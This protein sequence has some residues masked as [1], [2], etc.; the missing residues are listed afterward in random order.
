ML[1]QLSQLLT[2]VLQMPVFSVGLFVAAGLLAGYA[3]TAG[4]KGSEPDIQ[5][6][7]KDLHE[8]NVE[9]QETLRGQRDAHARLER[10]HA[11]QHDE[12]TRL[13]V[14]Q[15]RVEATLREH[16]LEHSSLEDS[17]AA[18][19]EIRQRAIRDLEQERQ[20]RIASEES[21]ETLARR[22]QRQRQELEE[23]KELYAAMQQE[24][25]LLQAGTR[26]WDQSQHD[27]RTVRQ[28]HDCLVKGLHAAAKE[29]DGDLTPGTPWN[30]AS[31]ATLL[32]RLAG[33]LQQT[34]LSLEH[35][36]VEHQEALARMHNEKQQRE[37]LSQILQDT[38]AVGRIAVPGGGDFAQLEATLTRT[39]EELEEARTRLN[40]S[41]EERSAMLLALEQGRELFR[42]LQSD[43][44]SHRRALETIERQRDEAQQ[45]L[46]R[47][48]AIP[49]DAELTQ[50][51]RRQLKELQTEH[52]TSQRRGVELQQ[53]LADLQRNLRSEEIEADRLR[54][55]RDELLSDLRAE[56]EE[57]RAQGVALEQQ[58]AK[59]R[60]L[61]EELRELKEAAAGTQA[62]RAELEAVKAREQSLLAS[63]AATQATI[64]QTATSESGP[65]F[66]A[67]P[68]HTIAALRQQLREAQ[69]A[70][71]E[72]YERKLIDARAP[73][74]GQATL[75]H[76]ATRGRDHAPTGILARLKQQSGALEANHLAAT[77]EETGSNA[78]SHQGHWHLDPRLGLVYTQPPE[79]RD[80][81]T[82][83]AAITPMMEGKLNDL[84]IY[85]FRQISEWS[86]QVMQEFSRL[87]GMPAPLI[88]DAW[89]GPARD[90]FSQNQGIRAA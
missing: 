41:A 51:L 27:L 44:E 16:Q 76:S 79:G 17:L 67:D 85:T 3:L 34:R 53:L 30:A 29:I 5:D 24:R 15:E 83:I 78:A 68:E 90:L 77:T 75:G 71:R 65:Y 63:A 88:E 39:R 7:L 25:E 28:E 59:L 6:S 46:A 26:E 86:P 12:W 81:L 36:R 60:R 8:Q 37:V 73:L 33:Q 18:L 74:S 38:E 31:A 58:T 32:T 13:R 55:Q 64:P 54:S 62:L 69:L 40:E 9:L 47:Q 1:S 56:Q 70:A 20:L 21:L 89:V 61:S 43:L 19:A 35:V 11:E 66:R 82:Q 57:R 80:P 49:S 42:A 22:E 52:S 14:M 48:M 84:G 72:T 50:E 45:Q 2:H 87:L 4:R 23:L 10:R